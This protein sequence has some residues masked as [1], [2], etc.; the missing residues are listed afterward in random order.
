MSN[1]SNILMW[2]TP[3]LKHEL[4]KAVCELVSRWQGIRTEE[5]M[6][7]AE[8]RSPNEVSAGNKYSNSIGPVFCHYFVTT[9]YGSSLGPQTGKVQLRWCKNCMGHTD[10][11]WT[12][13]QMVGNVH[14]VSIDD[15]SP[16]TRT[17]NNIELQVMIGFNMSS[18][19][20]MTL[21]AF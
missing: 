19:G 8:L 3:L 17:G 20:R 2:R 7:G 9:A 11:A 1:L 14:Q 15:P 12:Q 10:I 5:Q 21:P 6:D 4:I 16:V 18:I 13:C